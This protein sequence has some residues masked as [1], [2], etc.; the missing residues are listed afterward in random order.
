MLRKR[1]NK[2]MVKKANKENRLSF[3]PNKKPKPLSVQGQ[4]LYKK[5]TSKFVAKINKI[6][7]KLQKKKK[8]L[9]FH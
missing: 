2:T 3:K 7:F 5:K 9:Q 6:N 4:L 8:I 1:I